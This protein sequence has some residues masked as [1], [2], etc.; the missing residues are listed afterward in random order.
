M[1]PAKPTNAER[2]LNPASIANYLSSLSALGSSPN[3]IR[4][5][6]ADLMA[7]LSW[8]EQR[9]ASG[10]GLRWESWDE[11]EP[12]AAAYLT[13]RRKELAPASVTRKLG[14]FRSYAEHHGRPGFLRKYRSPS[15][16]RPKPHPIPEGMVAIHR[17]I[18]AARKP[19][20]KALLALCG[21][22]G[23]RVEEAINIRPC[24]VDLKQMLIVF[25]G[26]GSKVRRV[27]LSYEAFLAMGEAYSRALAKGTTL[28]GYSQSGA[29]KFIRAAGRK[30]GLKNELAS[31]DLRAT[32]ATASYKR[33]KDL[34]AVQEIL[35]HDDPKTTQ[36]YVET[37]FDDMRDAIT[38]PRPDPEEAG[39]QA[40]R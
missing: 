36:R 11:L 17:M 34:R 9:S 29:R 8:L 1:T 21:L 12:A 7:L 30:A 14:T 23:L 2:M 15:T 3:T 33:S 22:C 31:H 25:S 35:G 4:A 16:T 39:R 27:P 13:E 19:E 40:Q 18:D 5:Y 20:Q 24:H 28:T 32:L 10:D 38:H 6:R 26:K 37:T